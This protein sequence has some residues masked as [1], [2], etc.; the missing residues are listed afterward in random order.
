MIISLSIKIFRQWN[1]LFAGNWIIAALNRHKTDLA[2]QSSK[3]IKALSF[4]N[5][6]K[7]C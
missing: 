3:E 6:A 5:L 1:I 4:D 7:L 2:Q